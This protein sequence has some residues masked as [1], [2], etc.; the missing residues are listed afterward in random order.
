MGGIS[1]ILVVYRQ[2]VPTC[3]EKRLNL[4]WPVVVG[5]SYFG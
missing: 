5:Y 4:H 2:A 3:W 1:G